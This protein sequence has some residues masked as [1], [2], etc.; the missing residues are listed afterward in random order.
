MLLQMSFVIKFKFIADNK[1]CRLQYFRT[2]E[3][4]LFM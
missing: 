3:H 2:Y 4:W 1:I